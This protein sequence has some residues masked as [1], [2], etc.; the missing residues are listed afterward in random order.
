MPKIIVVL[1]K[2]CP[3]NGHS[4][5]LGIISE[6][7]TGEERWWPAPPDVCRLLMARPGIVVMYDSVNCDK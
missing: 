2:K 6:D 3:T 5:F 1:C 4:H 7:E